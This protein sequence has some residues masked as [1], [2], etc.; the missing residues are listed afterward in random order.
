MLAKRHADAGSAGAERHED[1][2]K[3]EREKQG[4]EQHAAPDIGRHRHRRAAPE[5]LN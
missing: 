4:G 1:G 5:L 2:G 3:A